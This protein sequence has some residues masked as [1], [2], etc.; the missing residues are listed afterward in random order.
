MQNA[1]PASNNQ[2]SISLQNDLLHIKFK[3]NVKYFEAIKRLKGSYFLKDKKVWALPIENFQNLRESQ[4]LGEA[5]FILNFKIEDFENK[6]IEKGQKKSE[7]IAK[8][9]ENCFSLSLTDIKLCDLDCYIVLDKTKKSLYLKYK[10]FGSLRT[11]LSELS[12][13]KFLKTY[14]A[15]YLP[16]NKIKEIFQYFKLNKISFAV[17]EEAATLLKQGKEYRDKLKS[18][19]KNLYFLDAENVE[20]ALCYPALVK[21]KEKADSFK[22]ICPDQNI[23]KLLK[24]KISGHLK[25]EKFFLN[26][27]FDEVL[28][29]LEISKIN[30]IDFFIDLNLEDFIY[31][32]NKVFEDTF[33]NN[34]SQKILSIYQPDSFWFIIDR[35]LY[36][37]TLAT[38]PADRRLIQVINNFPNAHKVYKLPANFIREVFDEIQSEL[39]LDVSK[40][41]KSFLD[42]LEDRERQLKSIRKLSKQKDAKLDLVNTE[43]H[44][45]LYPHQRVA[46]SWILDNESGL[47]GDDMGLGKTLSILTAFEEAQ[48][49]QQCDFLL[50]I[51]PQSLVENWKRE[52]D[53]WFTFIKTM[54]LVKTKAKR[55]K[56]LEKLATYRLKYHCLVL[57]FELIRVPDVFDGLIRLCEQRE[58]FLCVDESQRAKNP[59]SKTFLALKKISNLCK[60]RFLLSGTPLPRD[61]SD[62]WSQMYVIDQGERFGQSYYKWLSGIA[63]LGTKYSEYAVKK[64]HQEEV[65]ICINRVQEVLLR[66]KKEHVIDLPK[67]LFSVRNVE[68]KGDQLKRY[69]QV[70]KD[71]LVRLTSTDG[72][73]F[74]KEINNIL[75][76]YLRAV[77][78][79]SNPRL[80]DET[81]KGE[82]AKFLE[83]DALVD[84]IVA[85][86][87]EKLIIWTNYRGNTEELVERYEKFGIKAFTGG[88]NTK[89]RTQIVSEFQDKE[90]DLKILVA[91]PAAGGVGITLTAARTAIYLDKTWNAEHWMQS[92]DRIHRIGQE[93]VV[94]IISLYSSGVDHLIAKN[95]KKKTINQAKLLGDIAKDENLSDGSDYPSKADLIEAL[96]V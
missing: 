74:E 66:R 67:K 2:I 13:L 49:R 71:L 78:I 16:I 95:L 42:S 14:Y 77:Q 59:A 84:E 20:I 76:E 6:L 63:E 87:N 90:S 5:N 61:I 4:V 55:Q 25:R 81:F 7:A 18:F 56:D 72:E 47:L 53:Y 12:F 96:K 34:F 36:L 85:E 80:V 40:E 70:R 68:L 65:D 73:T 91:I 23:S 60:K 69:D 79:S 10:S 54:K 24:P 39:E 82:P 33:K 45:R 57:N 15:F 75:E 21:N 19:S 11:K 48:F 94:N 32:N 17:E 38:T 64:Y 52:T 22:I 8:Y 30:S 62:I 27:S 43:I 37:A 92:V 44:D 3:Y 58:V 86:K 46:I 9:N 89:E 88:I 28:K 83:L 41:V 31:E 35:E 51:S 29:I 50:V 93:H 1:V 26:L